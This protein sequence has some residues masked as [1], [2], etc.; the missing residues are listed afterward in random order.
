MIEDIV[1]IMSGSGDNIGNILLI[2]NANDNKYERKIYEDITLIILGTMTIQ[3]HFFAWE[4]RIT[5]HDN[6][7]DRIHGDYPNRSINTSQEI[8]LSKNRAQPHHMDY[9]HGPYCCLEHHTP[10]P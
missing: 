7:H 2:F 8:A 4:H 10:Y 3:S 1:V 9:P 6:L 5:K